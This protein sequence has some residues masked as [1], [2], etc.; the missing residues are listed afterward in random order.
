MRNPSSPSGASSAA[1]T[2]S[3]RAPSGPRRHQ[4][5]SASTAAASPSKTA[6]TDPSSR[7]RTHP[8]T[9]RR[10][11]SR[12]HVARKK[13]PCT[14]PQ[15]RTRR[16]TVTMSVRG[17]VR[18]LDAE[19]LLGRIVR[20]DEGLG[21]LLGELL[22]RE[23]TDHEPVLPSG[24]RCCSVQPGSPSDQYLDADKASTARSGAL[25]LLA[26]PSR[27]GQLWHCGQ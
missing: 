4:T 13:T 25:I 26:T 20:R 12:A 24:A 14:D 5:V 3:T 11:A 23:V 21:S 9:S 17:R 7:L 15:T 10:D 2:P 22:R 18:A 19:V 8:A 27:L 16:R 1:S 6:S